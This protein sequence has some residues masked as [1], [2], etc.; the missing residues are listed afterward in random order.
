MFTFTKFIRQ[1]ILMRTL[2]VGISLLLLATFSCSAQSHAYRERQ[3]FTVVEQPPEFPGGRQALYDYL[4]S[5]V[6]MPPEAVNAKIT[7]RV[8]ISFIVE[9]DGQLTDFQFVRSWG[10]G[11]DEEAMRVIKA[12]P[13]WKP[14]SQSGHVQRVKYN[15]PVLFGI[16]YPRLKGR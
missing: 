15:L 4:K 9:T 10:Y 8:I 16:D 2:S 12:M 7:D 13:R 5:N 14:G 11:C 3:V 1:P 6:Q